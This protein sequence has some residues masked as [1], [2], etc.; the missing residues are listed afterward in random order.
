LPECRRLQ[1]LLCTFSIF[2]N[3]QIITTRIQFEWSKQIRLRRCA[4]VFERERE[5]EMIS[6]S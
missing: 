2:S 4:F 6:A 3:I 5:R 1:N